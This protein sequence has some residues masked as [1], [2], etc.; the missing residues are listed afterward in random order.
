MHAESLQTCQNMNPATEFLMATVQTTTTDQG[1]CD[2]LRWNRACMEPL[3]G[4][5]PGL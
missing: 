2:W 3:P 1:L 4:F 5:C